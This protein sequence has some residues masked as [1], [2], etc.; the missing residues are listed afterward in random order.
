MSVNN[1][2]EVFLSYLAAT[3]SLSREYKQF[4]KDVMAEDVRQTDSLPNNYRN[5]ISN[6]E[7]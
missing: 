4:I 5:Q 6:E 7:V 2:P 1:V 3:D